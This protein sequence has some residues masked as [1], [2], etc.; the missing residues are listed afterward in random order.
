LYVVDL[1]FKYSAIL[2]ISSKD[3]VQELPT[4]DH[5]VQH[6]AAGWQFAAAVFKDIGLMV[7]KPDISEADRSCVRDNSFSAGHI[8]RRNCNARRITRLEDVDDPEIIGLM[9][10]DGFLVYLT[11]GGFVYRVNIS[12]ESFTSSSPVESFQLEHFVTHPKL[13]YISG[14]FN[15]FG[16]FNTAGDVLVGNAQ[17]MHD[18]NPAINPA[19]QRCGIIGLSWGDWHA[20]ALCENGQVLSW[21]RELRQNGCLGMGYVDS[22]DA[23]AMGLRVDG[24]EVSSPEPRKITQFDEDKFAFC[25][26]AAGW[27][28]AA[29]VADFKVQEPR[30][31]EW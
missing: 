18:T 15:H 29:L 7:W 19:L 31:K 13:S 20:L 27:H 28:S 22:E 25:V 23:T 16:L 14:S 17:T 21:G 10:G 9:V 26:A 11:K 24:G 6:M 8:M 5:S 1:D 30:R 2:T 3:I 12:E 4:Q